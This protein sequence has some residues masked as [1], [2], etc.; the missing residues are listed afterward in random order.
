LGQATFSPGEADILLEILSVDKKIRHSA[1]SVLIEPP[2][3]GA[4]EGKVPVDP[5]VYRFY[6]IL[7]VYG[8]VFKALIHEKFGDG[9]MSAVDF[10]IDVDKEKRQDGD[11]VKITLCGKFLPYKKW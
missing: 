9:V 10:T 8:T 11:Y 4:L 3:K 1:K 7:Q 5:V 6:E 2:M